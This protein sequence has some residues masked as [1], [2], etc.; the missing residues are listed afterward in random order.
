MDA[1]QPARG[2]AAAL[3]PALGASSDVQR[4]RSDLAQVPEECP[5]S[6]AALIK[7]CMAGQPDKRP[8][9]KEIF[10]SMQARL[11]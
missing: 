9:A 2:A 11:F 10:D 5:A 7:E 4:A 3:L 1:R 6:I 8:T